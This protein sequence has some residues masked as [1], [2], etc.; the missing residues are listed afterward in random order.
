MDADSGNIYQG[1][2]YGVAD[3]QTGHLVSQKGCCNVVLVRVFGAVEL[4]GTRL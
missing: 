3:N 1:R 4:V 2:L